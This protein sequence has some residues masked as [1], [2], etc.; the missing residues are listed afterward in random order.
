MRMGWFLGLIGASVMVGCG[1]DDDGSACF[2]GAE[3]PGGR[4]SIACGSTQCVD[5]AGYRCVGPDDF[6]SDPSACAPSG[7]AGP[8]P[9]DAGPGDVDAGPADT[10]AGP[11][12]ADAG[13][14]GCSVLVD[15]TGIGIT[16]SCAGENICICTPNMAC[17]SDCNA[18]LTPGTCEPA[19]P[20]R[21]RLFPLLAYVPPTKPD[22]SGWDADGSGPDL[23]VEMSVDGAGT[24]TTAT[25]NDLTIDGDGDFSAVYSGTSGDYNLVFGSSIDA[26]VNDE[27]LAGDDGAFVCTWTA[28]PALVRG[29]LLECEGELGGLYALVTP[30]L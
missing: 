20:R 12:P 2:C 15:E 14:N 16:D 10:D 18:C 27:D 4:L 25:A 6:V 29:R 3:V 24:I 26:S 1:G 21:Y 22:G 8:P 17:S 13:P 23:Y 30:L 7:D 11:P 5:G 19:L 9:M 28:N